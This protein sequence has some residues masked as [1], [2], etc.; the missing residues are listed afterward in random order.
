LPLFKKKPDPMSLTMA[1]VEAHASGNPSTIEQ[2]RQGL[3]PVSTRDILQSLYRFGQILNRA[4]LRPEQVTAI[5]E[6]LEI[7]AASPEMTAAVQNV[8]RAILIERSQPAL[9]EAVNTFGPPLLDSTSDQLRQMALTLAAIT[10]ST[11]RRLEVRF[12]WA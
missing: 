1:L 12:N 2:A 4:N 11:C 7:S 9:T 3:A 8:G 5:E 6:E 10:G